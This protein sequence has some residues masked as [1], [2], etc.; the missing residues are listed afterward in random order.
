MGRLARLPG[1]VRPGWR[2]GAP[3]ERVRHAGAALRQSCRCFRARRSRWPTRVESQ[4]GQTGKLVF[5]AGDAPGLAAAISRTQRV[6]S[7][8]LQMG[9]EACRLRRAPSEPEAPD[10]AGDPRDYCGGVAFWQ[11]NEP[12]PAVSWSVVDHAGRP[13]AAMPCCAYQP[14]L[15]AARFVR[16]LVPAACCR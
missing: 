4:L 14:L 10:S 1:L 12:W 9:I 7:A 13:K 11:F 8:A 2:Y 15:V 16:C 6:Q 5:Y 3:A